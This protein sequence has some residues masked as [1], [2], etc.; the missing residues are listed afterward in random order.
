LGESFLSLPGHTGPPRGERGGPARI[1]GPR[2][3]TILSGGPTSIL[4]GARPTRA[5][6]TALGCLFSRSETE[7]EKMLAAKDGC[8]QASL[9]AVLGFDGNRGNNKPVAL[10]SV[11]LSV[12][13]GTILCVAGG[14]GSGKTALLDV[15]AARCSP[16]KGSVSIFGRDA[17]RERETVRRLVGHVSRTR[18][19]LNLRATGLSNL[20]TVAQKQR[21]QNKAVEARVGE[22]VEALGLLKVIGDP[23]RTY[24]AGMR[25]RLAIARSLLAG[26]RLLAIDD[27]FCRLD[28]QARAGVRYL[29]PRWVREHEG[30]VVF[31]ARNPED[32]RGLADSVAIMEEGRIRTEGP[33]AKILPAEP[34]PDYIRP[35]SAGRVCPRPGETP[36]AE[37][38]DGE[39][40]I[41]VDVEAEGD[42]AFLRLLGELLRP[43]RV[44]PLSPWIRRR[45]RGSTKADANLATQD[46]PV[47]LGVGPRLGSANRPNLRCR[48]LAPSALISVADKYERSGRFGTKR[49][50]PLADGSFRL[51]Q[52]HHCYRLEEA[53]ESG[54][55]VE[56]LDGDIVRTHLS[57]GQLQQRDRDTNIRRIG[58][59]PPPQPQRRSRPR[60]HLS[61]RA[62]RNENVPSSAISWRHTSGAPLKCSRTVT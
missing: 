23:V 51:R 50:H 12:S 26:A 41:T 4:G 48:V 53:L 46:G 43:D 2:L 19:D 47:G 44:R 16:T 27:L 34:L 11:S 62:A 32:A 42:S 18:H 58:S 20:L 29:L 31:T 9:Y 39:D 37:R 28:P 61:Y 45:E 25:H 3:A 5:R 38:R 55:R 7:Q 57:K 35:R 40:V 56:V 10:H 59:W 17:Q 1:C 36:P 30:T 14:N 49:I 6:G 60:R 13:P 22:A 24:S 52:D 8:H 21:L 33:A 54:L 15:L